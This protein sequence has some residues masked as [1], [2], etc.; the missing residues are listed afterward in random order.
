MKR[1]LV[2]GGGITGLALA[3][4]LAAL[5]HSVTVVEQSHRF[6]G[7]MRSNRDKGFTF[8]VSNIVRSLT[9]FAKQPHHYIV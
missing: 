1:V 8:E 4:R 7:W 5:N 6:G 3:R 9:P 2:V